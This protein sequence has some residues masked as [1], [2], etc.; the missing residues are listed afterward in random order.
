MRIA[1]TGATGNIGT[2]VRRQLEADPRV[3][4]IRGIARRLPGESHGKTRWIAA[5]VAADDL[6]VHFHGCDAVIALAWQFH[7][8]RDPNATWRA[9]AI[10]SAR[11]F[12]AAADAGAGT[13]IYLSSVGAY[14]PGRD[15]VDES[16]PTHSM[17]TAAYGREKA[18]V[19]RVLDAFEPEHSDVRV[20]RFRPAFVFQRAAASEQRRIFAGPFVPGT[21][22]Q[23]GRLPF[24]PLPASL[25][26]QTVHADDVAAAVSSALHTDA[27]GPFNLA[28]EPV[29]DHR[30]MGELL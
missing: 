4:E 25:R 11:T 26:F 1:I 17:P 21:L 28:A 13:I 10:G 23:P 18:Y 5:D 27:C 7:P 15:R 19:E 12:D 6:R 29:I 3:D 14:S 22:V 2:A 8:T 20:V 9:N 16:W 24:V 30:V